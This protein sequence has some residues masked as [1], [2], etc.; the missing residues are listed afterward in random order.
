MHTVR[1][2]LEKRQ[3][4]TVFLPAVPDLKEVLAGGGRNIV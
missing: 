3:L 2:C 1:T 4:T